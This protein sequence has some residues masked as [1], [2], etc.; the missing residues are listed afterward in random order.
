MTM[1]RC[2]TFSW[3]L[4]L[5]LGQ[6]PSASLAQS[7]SEEAP[8]FKRAQAA[9]GKKAYDE[10]CASCHG[11]ELEGYQLSPALVGTRFDMTWR[12]KSADILTFHLRRMPPD[13]FD[14]P[15]KLSDETHANILAYILRSNG[16]EARGGE[17]PSDLD[18]LAKLTIPA[19][20]GMDFDPVVPV[21]KSKAQTALL[22]NLPPVTDAMLRN[23]SP[24]DWL[25]WGR[26]YDG[27]SY[28]PLD[29][30]NKKTVKDLKPAWRVPLLFGSSMPMPLVHQGVMF[31]HTFPDTVIAMDATNGA[32]LWRYKREGLTY[33]TK[34]MGLAL[35]EDR[36]YASTTDLHVI[37][38]NAKTGELVWDHEMDL[39]ESE[40]ARRRYQTR[41]APLI[42]GDVVIE[43]TLSFR[44]PKGN[45]IIG[46]DR[47]SGKEAWRFNTVAWPG[48]PGGNTWNGLP[49]AS[50]RAQR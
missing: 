38:L 45:F 50:D 21:V 8:S 46:I 6:W 16:F 2:T 27:Q 23:P 43:A 32:V 28:S 20:P 48:Q 11:P 40:S 33:S 29:Q 3:G 7:T 9:D 30:I 44:L 31:L 49:V 5:L 18:S 41:A 4:I 14:G 19:I 12:G 15:D 34:K 1:M 36:I 13:T 17:L 42:A 10:H 39:G 26:T 25:H 24:N 37:A 47:K 22:N 35:H